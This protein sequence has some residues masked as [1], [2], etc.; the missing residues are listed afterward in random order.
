MASKPTAPRAIAS[1]TAAATSS[2]W[3]GLH[4]AQHL[5][6]LALAG[7]LAPCAL[8]AGGLAPLTPRQLPAGQRGGVVEPGVLPLHQRQ[9]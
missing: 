1:P 9:E 5:H 4:Q 6:E 3:K 7:A 2:T 8:R